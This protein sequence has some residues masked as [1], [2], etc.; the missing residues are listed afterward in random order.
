MH[1]GGDGMTEARATLEAALAD[2]EALA[3]RLRAALADMD[4][5]VNPVD[6]PADDG[7]AAFD[8]DDMIEVS[9]AAFRFNVAEDTIR[10]WLRRDPRLGCK[11]GGRWRVSIQRMRSMT[12]QR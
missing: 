11:V 7:P 9:I 8:P 6:Y 10:S 2:A 1:G 3:G 5:E 4:G 12:G